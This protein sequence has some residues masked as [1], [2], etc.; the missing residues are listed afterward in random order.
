MASSAII[1]TGS[2][3]AFCLTDEQLKASSPVI[4]TGSD[5]PFFLTDEQL[6]DLPSI[7]DGID[8]FTELTLRM[9]PEV[10]VTGQLLL[11]WFYCKESFAHFNVKSVAAC[12][13]WLATE[14]EFCPMEAEFV[15]NRFHKVECR[16]NSS[17]EYLDPH[18]EE[19]DELMDMVETQKLISK[20][21]GFRLH[22]EFPHVHLKKFVRHLDFSPK[23]RE[24]A[25]L[26]ANKS[27][28]VVACGVV[29][30]IASRF[31]V[32]LPD[33]P[34]WWEKF[35]SSNSRIDEVCRMLDVLWDCPKPCYI[36]VSKEHL[37]A[38][39]STY[40]SSTPEAADTVAYLKERLKGRDCPKDKESDSDRGSGNS[41]RI[42]M[43]ME[44]D[45]SSSIGVSSTFGVKRKLTSLAWEYFER[46]QKDG[47][48]K[49]RCLK[50]KKEYEAGNSGT[51]NM[52][53]HI[54][55]CR[56]GE[57][58]ADYVPLDHDKYREKLSISIVKHNYPFS[59]VEHEG[60]RE[61]H[62][63]LNPE[64]KPLTRNTAKADV[65]KIYEKE[66]DFLRSELASIPGRVCLSTDLW[67]S[68]TTDSYMTLTAHY[69]DKNWDL[70]KKILIF[71]H[72]V[73]TT[74]PLLRGR[75]NAR[76]ARDGKADYH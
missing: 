61:L 38:G 11:H 1:T 19:N 14:F 65:L 56:D 22:L 49:G 29:C 72:M 57:K 54:I 66:K 51:S 12:C 46:F 58:Q 74:A 47:K 39:R 37:P 71:R 62:S 35:V 21:L 24:Q 3:G 75:E 4:T 27:G 63:F 31:K 9:P 17:K 26:L 40:S 23:L 6:K 25:W 18:F 69:V 43:D 30:A 36:P 2:D 59:Y 34:P 60:T 10:K 68:I 13:L 15:I 44:M 42:D 70:Q 5:G 50:C 48:E 20:K 28:P 8:E 7:R 64:V 33:N 55:K 76:S 52:L 53:R 32:S 16:E 41:G 45:E 67:T 73:T